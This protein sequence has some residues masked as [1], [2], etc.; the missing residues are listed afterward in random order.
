MNPDALALD[1]AVLLERCRNGDPSALKQLVNDYH[2]RVFGFVL[3]LVGSDRNQAYELTASG[4]VEA[5][6]SLQSSA[7]PRSWWRVLLPLLL[8]LAR[9]AKPPPAFEAPPVSTL[10]PEKQQLLRL[11]KQALLR[12]LTRRTALI[13]AHRLSTIEHADRV[14]VIDEGRILEQGRHAELMQHP[15]GLYRRYALRQLAS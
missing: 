2:S 6:R 9:A 4:F 8:N 11:I 3:C 15:D 12:L 7:R 5:V 13:I 10:T 14:V 1:E